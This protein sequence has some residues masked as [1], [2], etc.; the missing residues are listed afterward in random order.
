MN[1]AGAT[2]GEGL[3]A[4]LDLAEAEASPELSL[5]EPEQPA[6]S[7]TGTAAQVRRLASRLAER[8]MVPSLFVVIRSAWRATVAVARLS[9][10]TGWGVSALGARYAARRGG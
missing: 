3:A 7:S 6:T 8:C 10:R 5:S 9:S 4:P 1:F 2:V